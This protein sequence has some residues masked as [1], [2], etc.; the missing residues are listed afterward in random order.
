MLGRNVGIEIG[1]TAVV[2]LVFPAL[3]LLR[4]TI[5]Y[6]PFFF[7]ASIALAVISVGWMIERLFS[8]DLFGEQRDDPFVEWPRSGISIAIL[9]LLA[10]AVHLHEKRSRRSATGRR[11][12]DRS[13]TQLD[14]VTP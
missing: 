10:A 6:R 9:T 11:T 4:R 7:V 5:Y 12:V 14:S 8:V 2:F 3:F 13:R 1:Q